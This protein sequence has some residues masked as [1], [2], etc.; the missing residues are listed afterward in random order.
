M[1]VL[2]NSVVTPAQTKTQ[3]RA[4]ELLSLLDQY[5]NIKVISLDC[6]DTIIWRRTATP[7]DLF[8]DLQSTPSYTAHHFNAALRVQAESQARQNRVLTD[9]TNEVTLEHIYTQAFPSLAKEQI[10]AFIEDEI[11]AELQACYSF[12]PLIE[13]MRAVIARGLKLIIVSDTYFKEAQLR[14]LLE[15][16]LPADIYAGIKRIFCSCEYGISKRRGIFKKVL[17][18][19][20]EKASTILHL[21]DDYEADFLGPSLQQ[22]KTLQLIYN[23]DIIAEL[24]R[25]Q[26]LMSTIIE[27]SIRHHKSLYNPFRG[28]FANT[29]INRDEPESIIGYAAT[30]PIMYI[31]AKF[32]LAEITK[33]KAEYPNVKV[34][35]LM[36]DAYLPSLAC[37]ALTGDNIGYRVRI[38]RFAAFASSFRTKEDVEKYLLTVAGSKRFADISKQLMLPDAMADK[39][40]KQTMKSSN[41]PREFIHQATQPAVIKVILQHSAEYRQRLMRHLEKEA[42]V[43]TGDTLIF[44]DLGYS[45]TAQRLLEPVF[46]SEYDIKIVGRYLLQLSIPEWQLSRKGLMDPSWCDDRTLAAVVNYIA[47]LEQISTS[48]DPSVVDYDDAG[49]PIFSDTT[50]GVNQHEKLIRI[51]KECIRFCKDAEAFFSKTKIALSPEILRETALFGL[52]RMLFLPTQPEINFLQSF[53]FDLNLGTE[54][55]LQ[56]FDEEAGLTGLRRRGLFFM[57]KNLKSMRTN[58]PAELRSAG[59]ELAITLFTQHRFMFDVRVKDLSLRRKAISLIVMKNGN[60]TP[61]SIDAVPTHDGYFSLIIPIGHGDYQ[62]GIM[63]GQHFQYVQL[64]SAEIILTKSLYSS[65]ESDHTENAIDQLAID[66]MVDLGGGL[67]QCQSELGMLFV[68]PVVKPDNDNYVLRVVFRPIVARGIT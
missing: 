65:K 32:I 43:K 47:L 9:G 48:N 55:L 49:N 50:V 3:V 15:T 13:F 40:I 36:R 23:E 31:F 56:M 19:I 62:A 24:S 20:P 33:V 16:H 61:L 11:Q 18:L 7:A 53:Q 35:F 42:D 45:G 51:Q 10:D 64:E 54:D 5:P 22:V 68:N 30:G 52:A 12:P 4:T 29:D 46:K 28:V 59:L 44:V 17:A 41:T 67:F 21:G 58:Y 37:H 57:E 27:P 6:F 34:L 66:Q 26:A 25:M 63:F 8:Y 38:S 39:L 14:R 1:D 60:A 2:D